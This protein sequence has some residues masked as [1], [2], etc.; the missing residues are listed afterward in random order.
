M[1]GLCLVV[2][3]IFLLEMSFLRVWLFGCVLRVL[4]S[5]CFCILVVFDCGCRLDMVGM[6]WLF[7]LLCMVMWVW[8]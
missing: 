8:R 7:M 1:S 6:S 3:L 4:M 2:D 5:C